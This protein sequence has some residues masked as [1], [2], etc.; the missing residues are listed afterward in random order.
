ME[1]FDSIPEGAL[2]K[3]MDIGG[4]EPRLVCPASL[5]RAKKRPPHLH[6]T[7]RRAPHNVTW[8]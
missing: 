7:A 3:E 8:I 5:Q 1:P 4:D 6:T 2:Q